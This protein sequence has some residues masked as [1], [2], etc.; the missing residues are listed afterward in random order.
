[1]YYQLGSLV[2][3]GVPIIQALE[4]LLRNPPSSAF[5][6]PLSRLIFQINSGQNFAGA[7]IQ[8]GQWISEF[9]IALLDAGERSGR[10]E[11][12]FKILANYYRERG[13]LLRQVLSSLAY[14]LLLIH[15]AVLI[16]PT[17]MLV[18]LVWRGE[19]TPFI[20]QKLIIFIPLYALLFAIAYIFQGE[21]GENLRTTVE[22]FC[23]AIPIF[24]SARRDLALA[25]LSAALEALINAGAP[26]FEA[27]QLASRSSGSPALQRAVSAWRPR[28]EAG[29]TPAELLRASKQF[30]E[31]FAN[32]YHSGEISGKQDETLR[33][34]YVVAQWMP[35]LVYF[36]VALFIAWQVISFWSG[37]FQQINTLTR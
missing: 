21:R 17:S 37:Y 36:G 20:F 10:L 34:L 4:Q 12:C 6:E 7:M 15:L 1:L 14:P 16:I 24:G 32:L 9:D 27:W 22:N 31:F 23:A 5:R 11:M 13:K 3:A 26:V 19:V 28:F 29:E 18:A 30:P 33:R 25:R 35:K 2:S 8:S